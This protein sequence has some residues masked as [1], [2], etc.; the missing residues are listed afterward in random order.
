[1]G[2]KI[3]KFKPLSWV[4]SF[5]LEVSILSICGLNAVVTAEVEPIK[6]DDSNTNKKIIEVSVNQKEVLLKEDPL[7]SEEVYILNEFEVSAE[8]DTGYLSAHTLSGSRTNALIKDTPMTVTVINEE[9]INDLNLDSLSDLS[10]VVASMDQDS[11]PFQIGSA[12]SAKIRG[13][14]SSRPLFD[15]FRRD[16]N[17]NS[18]NMGRTEVAI[19]TNS[20]VFGQAEPG[21]KTNVLP[22]RALFFN[23]TSTMSWT[24]GDH[25]SIGIFDINKQLSELFGVRI[26]GVTSSKDSQNSYGESDYK[27]G[28]LALTFR[29]SSKTSLQLHLETADQKN[30]LDVRK[31]LDNSASGGTYRKTIDTPNK[32]SSSG[33]FPGKTIIHDPNFVQYLPQEYIDAISGQAGDNATIAFNSRQDILNYMLEG[34]ITPKNLSDFANGQEAKEKGYLGILNLMHIFTDN[35]QAKLSFIHEDTRNDFTRQSNGNIILY[36]VKEDGKGYDLLTPAMEAADETHI[37]SGW[38]GEGVNFQSNAIRA[39]L[40]WDIEL[41]KS[42]HQ[43]LFGFD[44]DHTDRSKD[45]Y[46]LVRFQDANFASNYTFGD[47][48]S[49]NNNLTKAVGS[50]VYNYYSLKAARGLVPGFNMSSDII[51]SSGTEYNKGVA[52]Q[53]ALQSSESQ[54]VDIFAGW[55]AIQSKFMDGR[56]STMLGVRFDRTEIDINKSVYQSTDK[57][58]DPSAADINESKT[59]DSTSPSVGAVYWFNKNVGIYASYSRSIMSPDGVQVDAL[60]NSLPLTIGEGFDLGFRFEL[61]DGKLY[62]DVTGYHIIKENDKGKNMASNQDVVDYYASKGIT[63]DLDDL[64]NKILPGTTLRS[65]G[66]ESNLNF[67]PNRSAS[68]RFSYQTGVSDY[69]ESPLG[70]ATDEWVPGT[71]RHNLRLT[72]KYT[73]RDGM[74]RGTFIGLN[75]RYASKAFYDAFRLSNISEDVADYDLKKYTIWL[76]ET[77]STELFCGWKG[78]LPWAKGRNA[79]KYNIRLNFENIFDQVRLNKR[80]TY[81]GGREFAFQVGATW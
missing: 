52:G 56:L 72:G 32:S 14:P 71:S 5:F 69:K 13:I 21:G 45:L 43:L 61:L 19:G 44:Y 15:F 24:F 17:M 30:K 37:Q 23:D 67:N 76:P 81:M 42:K 62:G 70:L 77:Y 51:L 4:V 79:A 34:G 54:E 18:Y 64:V 28:T 41:K 11:D 3:L 78:Q 20:L 26:M 6:F 40:S 8:Q 22:K 80:G 16:L 47:K 55:G 73:F 65:R 75:Q 53:W 35:I 66:V 57:N 1:M 10:K 31:Y 7:E 33:L 27:A 49:I 2:D 25:R 29:P 48:Y 46:K 36:D 63:V 74:L 59:Y 68:F 12:Q 38:Q 9:L 50:L 58:K 39:T 60:G